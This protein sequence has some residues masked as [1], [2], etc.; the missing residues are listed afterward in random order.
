MLVARSKNPDNIEM[1]AFCKDAE[2]DQT[3]TG[4]DLKAQ[5]PKPK[6]SEHDLIAIG[7][8]KMAC[9]WYLLLMWTATVLYIVQ[10]HASEETLNKKEKEFIQDVVKLLNVF[11]YSLNFLFF[12]RAKNFRDTCKRRWLPPS[13]SIKKT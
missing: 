2:T 1:D 4:T 8:V 12:M 3:S 9:L 10:M 7:T 11:N 13:V 5:R 6:L